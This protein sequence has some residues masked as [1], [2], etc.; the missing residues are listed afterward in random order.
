MPLLF[1]PIEVLADHGEEFAVVWR[2]EL[3]QNRNHFIRY[4]RM[5]PAFAAGQTFVVVVVAVM[6]VLV[7]R[8]KRHIVVA[9]V[10]R[11]ARQTVK[12]FGGVEIELISAD[13][14]L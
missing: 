2:K 10:G 11:R 9:D 7:R 1:R 8:C 4:L 5:P 3:P 13:Q 6:A 14:M 12:S